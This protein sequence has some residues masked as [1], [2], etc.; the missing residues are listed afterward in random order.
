[1]RSLAAVAL[2][3]ALGV[4]SW[5]APCR[6]DPDDEAKGHLERGLRLY[7]TQAYTEAIA[8]FKAG[9]RIDPRPSFLYALAQAQR[10]NGDCKNA[11]V[12]YRAFLR[13]APAEPARAAAQSNI[14]RCEQA[15]RDPSSPAARAV[16][17]EHA[18]VPEDVDRAAQPQ[19]LPAAPAAARPSASARA[20][21]PKRSE[22]RAVAHSPWY[23]DP[24]GDALGVAGIA[25]LLAGAT[26]LVVGA[27][28]ANA[29]GASYDEHAAS[30]ETAATL[31]PI[32]IVVAASGAAL[33]GGAIVRYATRPV[34]GAQSASLSAQAGPNGLAVRFAGRF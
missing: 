1:V 3:V 30:R 18:T 16:D 10:M 23:E 15:Q 29:Q 13:S 11:V 33:V 4:S 14:E 2:A 5:A 7:D 17:G 32:G 9:Y 24:L 25:G 26:L 22:E 12:A 28:E 21:A 34:P 8:E 6:A 19:P 20:P 27:V 31:V